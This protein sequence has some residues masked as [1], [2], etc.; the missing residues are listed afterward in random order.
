VRSKFTF[1]SRS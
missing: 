1:D